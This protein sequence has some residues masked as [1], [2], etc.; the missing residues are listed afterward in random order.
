MRGVGRGRGS[1]DRGRSDR[2]SESRN[3]VGRE[4]SGSIDGAPRRMQLHQQNS[5]DGEEWETASESSEVHLRNDVTRDDSSKENRQTPSDDATSHSEGKRDVTKKSF[6]SQRPSV[7]QNRR[8]RR[9]PQDGRSSRNNDTSTAVNGQ[10]RSGA[11]SRKENVNVSVY[12][13]DRIEHSNPNAMHSAISGSSVKFVYHLRIFSFT[14]M[15]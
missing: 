5:L 8:E 14:L 4:G 12:R 6:S 10:T 9:P 1:S 15:C 7:N 2:V 3:S 13:V 11:S